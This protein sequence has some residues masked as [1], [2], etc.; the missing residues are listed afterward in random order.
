MSFPASPIKVSA[1]APPIKT[2]VPL[3][4]LI[5]FTELSPT[6]VS[7]LFEPIIFWISYNLSVPSPVAVCV[8][9]VAVVSPLNSI[10]EFVEDKFTLTPVDDVL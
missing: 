9:N 8:A 10:L 6:N 7:V 3:P 5:V 2:S 4:A 1:P